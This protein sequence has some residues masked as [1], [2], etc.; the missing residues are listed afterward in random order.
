MLEK[1]FLN[2]DDTIASISTAWGEAGIAIVRLSGPQA[3]DIAEKAFRGIKP[4]KDTPPRYMRNGFLLDERG[5][6]IDEVLGVWF[7]APKSYTGE[8]V[9]EIHCHGGLLVASKCLE[10]LT[11]QG[12]RLAEPGEFTQRAF[13]NGRIDLTQAEAVL[14]VI[15]AKSDEAL[16]S[17]ARTL[18]GELS[19]RVNGIY[20]SL[21]NISATLEA[22]LDFPEE[23]IPYLSQD[24]LFQSLK[25]IALNLQ[26]VI[27]RCK[28]GKALRDG[29]KVAIVGRP[30]VGKSSIFNALLEETRA[31]VTPIPGTT[32]DIIEGSIVHRGIPI[33]FMDTAGLRAT[34]DLVETIGVSMAQKALREADLRLWIIDGSEQLTKEEIDMAMEL[35]NHS[36]IV[37]INKADIPQVISLED[38]KQMLPESEI[39]VL[40]S[41]DKEA[42]GELKERIVKKLFKDSA[43]NEGFNATARQIETLKSVLSCV[44]NS[45]SSLASGEPQDLVASN[46]LEARYYID[47]LLGRNFDED[48]IHLIFSQ[49]CVGK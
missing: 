1:S 18:R 27:Y 3:L 38:V 17:A 21:L 8:D 32:R 20:D 7:R 2:L 4:L 26:D 34:D 41:Y 43:I 33:I 12:A 47:R 49:F 44:E 10:L 37:A 14:G 45:I 28:V 9:V 35:K 25:A 42:I 36:H 23:D 5:A 22:N 6:P 11:A 48:L 46:L 30:N 15:R 40:S 13:L 31:I 16:L 24:D 29:I 19:A 39:M